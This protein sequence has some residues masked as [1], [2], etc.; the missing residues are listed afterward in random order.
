MQA[1]RFA[2]ALH[3]SAARWAATKVNM[4]A[5]SPT[6][7]EGIVVSWAKKEGASGGPWPCLYVLGMR[8]SNDA[9]SPCDA[10][11]AQARW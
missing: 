7:T 9:A 8:L 2:R 6:M 3:A 1:V 4:P 10:W 11:C 5:M